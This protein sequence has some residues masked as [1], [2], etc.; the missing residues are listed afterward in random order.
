VAP[1]FEP[2]ALKALSDH[3]RK[4][5]R[6]GKTGYT[7]KLKEKLRF[8]AYRILGVDPLLWSDGR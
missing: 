6:K 3:V 8:A 5:V 1:K 7:H 2:F 4:Y